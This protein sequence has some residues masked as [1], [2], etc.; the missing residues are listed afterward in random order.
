MQ[1]KSPIHPD[2]VFNGTAVT[3]ADEHKHLGL[4]LQSNLSFSKH[5][6]EKMTKAKKI[7]GILKH[8]SKFLPLKTLNQMYKALVRSHLDYCDII[9]HMPQVVHPPPL[10]VS[11]HN[12]MESVEKIQYQAGLAITGCWKG[13]SRTKLYEELGWETLSD[14]RSNNRVF[15]IYKIISKTT[16]SYLKD[17]LPPHRYHFLVHVFR[18]MRCKS[19]R[20][21]YSFFPDAISSWNTVISQFEYFPIYSRFKNHVIGSHRPKGKPVFDIHD[22]T[23][24]RYLFQLRLGLS[25]LR[26][27]K[28]RYGFRDT[29]SDSC[30]CGLGTED[31]R[32]FL[33][34]CPFY[35]TKRVVMISN[36][37]E[38]LL[39]N[40]LNYPTH[41]PA[42]E[43]DLYL[44]GHPSIGFVDNRSILMT[45]IKFIKN[46]NR[47]SP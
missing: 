26:S 34:S 29:P 47:F 7:I 44:Y 6:N 28:V 23:G 2:L 5:L 18:E 16:L 13:T 43:L 27:H 15:Q 19:S 3:K 4:T 1:K 10:G 30:L 38:I 36:V 31:T 17:K 35:T 32:H 39:N 41:F 37:E 8:L 20:Y 40:N 21:S 42:N 33:F 11:L 46:T 12:L 22:P 24:L 14:R 25:P 9:Y 45:T